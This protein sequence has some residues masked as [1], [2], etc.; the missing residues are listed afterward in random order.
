MKTNNDSERVL[1]KMYEHLEPGD[2]PEELR[3]MYE[4][5]LFG[6]DEKFKEKVIQRIYRVG[7]AAR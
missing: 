4:K 2:V 7:K 6:S 1:E 3:K 5:A